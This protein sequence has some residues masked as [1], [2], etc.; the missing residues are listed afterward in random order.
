MLLVNVFFLEIIIAT[1][2]VHFI[3]VFCI[4]IIDFYYFIYNS[5]FLVLLYALCFTF[6]D[7][8]VHL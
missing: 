7:V 5:F 2:L 4:F 8:F 6:L 3:Y 1:N